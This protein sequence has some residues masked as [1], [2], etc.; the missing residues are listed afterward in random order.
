MAELLRVILPDGADGLAL[1][2]AQ[3]RWHASELIRTAEEC[4]TAAW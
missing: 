3:V 1:S 2:L 4:V